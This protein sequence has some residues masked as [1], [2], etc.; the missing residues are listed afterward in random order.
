[1]AMTPVGEQQLR[2]FDEQGYFVAERAVP[3]EALCLLRRLCDEATAIRA[4]GNQ[5]GNSEGSQ[6]MDTSSGRVFA[7][8]VET[9]RPEMY[10]A[11]LGDWAAKILAPLVPSCYLFHSEFV[12]KASAS[13]EMRYSNRFGWHQDGGYGTGDDNSEGSGGVE[14]L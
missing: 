13:E 1:M 5:I 3:P 7:F 2:Q 6:L 14:S 9:E 10:S 8:N 12:V 4:E 11:L